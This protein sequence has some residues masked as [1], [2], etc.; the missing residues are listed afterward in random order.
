MKQDSWQAGVHF[1]LKGSGVRLISSLGVFPSNLY[2][3]ES[4]KLLHAHHGGHKPFLAP[5]TLSIHIETIKLKLK[6]RHFPNL[7]YYSDLKKNELLIA[8]TAQF[9]AKLQLREQ[10]INKIIL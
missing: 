6:L 9:I 7:W 5:T 4:H 8:G 10:V 2:I 3:K 1:H